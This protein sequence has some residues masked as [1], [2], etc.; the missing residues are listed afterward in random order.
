MW[1]DT[2]KILDFAYQNYKLLKIERGEM[3][4]LKVKDSREKWV[5]LGIKQQKSFIFTK[6]QSP[7]INV[8]ISSKILAPV[9]KYT[10]VGKIEIKFDHQSYS[11]PI[12]TLQECQ[13]KTFWDILKEKL[14]KQKRS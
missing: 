11:L 6:D 2:K 9:K 12:V 10:K 13:R 14:F 8:I 7:K 1:N 5:K 4:Y 3:G